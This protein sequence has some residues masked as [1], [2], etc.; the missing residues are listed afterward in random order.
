MSKI[1]VVN[2][3]GS[4]DKCAGGPSR[5]V[6]QT[7]EHL[8]KLS[9]KIELITQR[10]GNMVNIN[11][12][13]NF[14]VT[15]KNMFQLIKYGINLSL[16]DVDLIHLQHIWE[17]YIHIMAFFARLKKI[18]YIITPRGMLEPWIMERH[19][20]KKQIAMYL[21]Q[22]NDLKKAAC[23]HA[24]CEMEVQN[25][26]KLGFLNPIALIPNGIDISTVPEI[27]KDF[28]SKK[29]IF[30]SRIHVKKGL[31]IL[32]DSWKHICNNGWSLEIAGEGDENYVSELKQKIIVER[33]PNVYFIGA[34]YGE[35][36]WNF[37]KSGDVFV[38]PTFS[39]NFGIVV[40]EALAIGLPV[41]TTKGTPWGE[42]VSHKCGWWIDLNTQNLTNALIEATNCDLNEL[43][44]K[45]I[46]GR[47]LVEKCY[48]IAT[49]AH[50]VKEMYRYVTDKSLQPD[51]VSIIS[52]NGRP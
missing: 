16:N 20:L 32:L 1:R 40:A 44:S 11:V 25:I 8:S 2:V 39:E 42:L 15:F 21:Y 51:N 10:S 28:G 37:L 38:L 48:S 36:K 5:S 4:I 46:R 24:T 45:G 49:V 9:V 6:P 13:P 41:I 35:D 19:P 30:L 17:P 47:Q 33:I 3:I 12:S 34:L 50:N 43:K 52:E 27:K 29:I 14:K 18:P 31:G 26:R 22:R 23:L 7:C